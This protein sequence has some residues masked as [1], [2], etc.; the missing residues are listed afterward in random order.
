MLWAYGFTFV[1]VLFAAGT[2]L[3]IWTAV[4]FTRPVKAPVVNVETSQDFRIAR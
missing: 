4:S 2:A 3:L 1:G